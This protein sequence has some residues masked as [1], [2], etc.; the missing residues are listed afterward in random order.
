MTTITETSPIE[1]WHIYSEGNVHTVFTPK[2]K[3]KGQF[4]SL[5][6]AIKCASAF[7]SEDRKLIY[8]QDS[9]GCIVQVIYPEPELAIH[10]SEEVLH[11]L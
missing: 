9:R 3:K 1:C 5:D 7:T 6:N 11:G 8:I 4:K 2:L 10:V